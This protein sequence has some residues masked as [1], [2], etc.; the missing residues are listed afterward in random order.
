MKLKTIP[1]F[2]PKNVPNDFDNN[3]DN[4]GLPS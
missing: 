2:P 3:H 1:Q 4:E